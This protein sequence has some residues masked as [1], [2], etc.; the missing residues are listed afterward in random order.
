MAVTIL[1]GLSPEQ[2]KIVL[3]LLQLHLPGVVVWAYGSRMRG[4]ANAKSDLDLVVFAGSEKKLQVFS[5]KEAFDESNLPFRVDLFDW[6]ELPEDFRN[7]IEA[8]HLVLTTP[9]SPERGDQ[10]TDKIF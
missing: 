9:Q 3:D 7:N 1:P 4:T 10:P 5:L 8:G 6:S 2:Q